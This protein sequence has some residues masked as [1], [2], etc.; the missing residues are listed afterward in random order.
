MLFANVPVECEISPADHARPGLRAAGDGPHWPARS[1]ALHA[2]AATR[3]PGAARNAMPSCDGAVENSP[4][5]RIWAL[6]SS[7]R[8]LLPQPRLLLPRSHP[9]VGASRFQSALFL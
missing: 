6:V 1:H 2:S 3:P 7:R 4:T 9:G 5:R 8:Q